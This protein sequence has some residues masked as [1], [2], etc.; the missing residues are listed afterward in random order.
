M[1]AP[2]KITGGTF[3]E[4]DTGCPLLLTPCNIYLKTNVTIQS[5][6]NSLG[7]GIDELIWNNETVR[8][9]LFQGMSQKLL[10]Y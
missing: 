6:H 5:F 10:W 7:C 8:E 1:M 3:L 2:P 4:N 9:I